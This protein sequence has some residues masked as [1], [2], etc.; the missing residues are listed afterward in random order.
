MTRYSIVSHRS[1]VAV[2]VQ[3]TLQRLE[4]VSGELAGE[5]EAEFRDGLLAP[6]GAIA[7]LAVPSAS[8]GSGN[9]LI[10]RDV[11][12]MFEVR[13]FPEISGE[14][15]EL[16]TADGTGN[17]WVRGHLSLH[18]VTREVSGRASV[19]ETSEN[20][21]V[22]EGAMTLDYTLFNLIPPK[23]LMLKVEPE[24]EIRGRVYAERQS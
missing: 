10:D 19:V 14:V 3:S 23:L 2:E 20:H 21:A 12:V 11:R 4:L 18:G 22:I 16:K 9:W 15:I 17:F 13:K 7:S 1:R 24:V 8:F 6:A 5:I